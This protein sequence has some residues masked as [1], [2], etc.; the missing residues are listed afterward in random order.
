MLKSSRTDVSV[1]V[2]FAESCL[3]VADAGL[4]PADDVTDLGDRDRPVA[5]SHL[6]R[7]P[8]LH[9]Y[10]GLVSG[11]LDVGAEEINSV[12]ESTAV[13]YLGPNDAARPILDAELH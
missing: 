10:F 6:D 9:P 4:D 13:A 11:A 5:E 1:Q 2:S 7:A 8:A 3:D 12:L